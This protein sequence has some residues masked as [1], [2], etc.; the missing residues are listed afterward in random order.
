MGAFIYQWI[1]L[2]WLPVTWFVAHRAHRAGLTVFAATCI[3]TMRTQVE[4]IES[5][6]YGTGFLPFL[7][8]PLYARGLVVYSLVV[9]LF[10]L[11]AHYSP[12]VSGYVFLAAG[13]TLYLFAFCLALLVM[14]L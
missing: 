6:G 5:T 9:A 13:I 14:A 12:R 1:D 11:L 4:L 10:L 3:L 8:G 2:L 7:T